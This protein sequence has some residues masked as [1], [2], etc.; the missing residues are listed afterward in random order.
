MSDYSYPYK[1][2]EFIFNE[3]IDFDQMCA[4]AGLDEMNAELAFAVLE[5]ANRMGSELIAPLNVV[6]APAHAP[7]ALAPLGACALAFAAAVVLA[8][9]AIAALVWR[10]AVLSPAF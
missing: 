5:E 1:D 10:R 4:Q 6:G 3:L 9:A 7:L 8:L 2:A